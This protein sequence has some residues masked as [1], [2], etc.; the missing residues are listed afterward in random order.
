[1][2]EMQCKT[3][4]LLNFTGFCKLDIFELHAY[5]RIR[6]KI[7]L[8]IYIYTTNR[9]FVPHDGCHTSTGQLAVG[10]HLSL[11]AVHQQLADSRKTG[12]PVR[13]DPLRSAPPHHWNFLAQG[14][15][16]VRLRNSAHQ[17]SAGRLPTF[18]MGRPHPLRAASRQQDVVTG[19]CSGH[20]GDLCKLLE[21]W[22][23]QVHKRINSRWPQMLLCCCRSNTLT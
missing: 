1:M 10:A 14:R 23:K 4:N 20:R 6:F 17:E 19:G 16:S 21:E 8:A 11:A 7:E 12:C 13:P 15:C 22:C 2:I 5:I 9:S 3:K 18:D